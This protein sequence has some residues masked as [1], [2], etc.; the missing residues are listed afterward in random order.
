MIVTILVCLRWAKILRHSGCGT[1]V[2]IDLLPA[3]LFGQFPHSK[4]SFVIVSLYGT[5]DRAP[6]PGNRFR[7]VSGAEIR[8][9]VFVLF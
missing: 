7:L 9:M 3:V 4:V 5:G 6:Y 1:P 2:E 8:N